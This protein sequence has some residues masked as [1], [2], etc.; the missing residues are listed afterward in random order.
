MSER[1][2]VEKDSAIGESEVSPESL[3]VVRSLDIENEW[4]RRVF[5]GTAPDV[6]VQVNSTEFYSALLTKTTIFSRNIL[7]HGE[8]FPI[9][10][11]F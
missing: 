9:K 11:K 4:K 1:K 5:V 6:S 3:R 2:V 8:N 10:K 7:F